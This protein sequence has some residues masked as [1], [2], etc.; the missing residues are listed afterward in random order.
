MCARLFQEEASRVDPDGP[1]VGALAPPIPTNIELHQEARLHCVS[2]DVFPSVL[3]SW[4][5]AT[6]TD[7]GTRLSNSA[8]ATGNYAML[9]IEILNGPVGSDVEFDGVQLEEGS[10]PKPYFD[11]SIP[12]AQWTGPP[13]R[14]ASI[15]TSVD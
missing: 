15:L 13:N 3:P 7:V 10:A 12:P 11:G 14:S 5:T 4:S 8:A 9:E 1:P 6:S 2:V